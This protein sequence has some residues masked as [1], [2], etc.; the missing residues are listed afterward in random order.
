M[1]APGR[2]ARAAPAGHTTRAGF[3]AGE[4]GRLPF[5]DAGFDSTY[6]VAVLQHV[7]DVDAAVREFAR[8]TAGGGRVVAVEPDNGARYFYSSTQWGRRASQ[9]AAQFFAAVAAER[10]DTT[11]AS[12]GP[13][14]R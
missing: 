10:R 2:A 7:G 12:V 9:S 8:V 4:G 6:C 14:L 11:D 5:K 1:P 3:A 13:K